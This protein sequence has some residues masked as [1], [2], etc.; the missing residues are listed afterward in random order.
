M[1]QL[2]ITLD[3]ELLHGLFTKDSRDEAFSKLLETILNQV[4]VAQSA[5][6]LGAERYERCEDRTAY[7]NGFRDRE[8][9]TRIGGITLRIPRHRNGEFSTTMFQRYQRSEQ[10]L[11]LAM[12]EMVI[13]GVS[14][15]KIE[16]ITEELC[17]Q[18]FSKSTVSKLCENLDPVVNGFRNRTL[19]KHYPFIIVDALY[20]KVRE[21]SR[22]RSKGLLVATAVNENGNREVIGFQLNDTETE[23][24]W[25]D[26]F[27]NLKE[28]GLTA[29]DLIVS[30]NH[31]GLVNAI[32]K[33]F[34]GSTWQRC[35]THFSRN[36]L[37]KT[38]KNQQSELKSYL[39]R[40]YNAVNIEDARNLLKDTLRHFESKAPKAIEIL[41]E[42]FDDVMA[43]MS[44]PEKYRKRLRTTNSIERLN[45]EIR[46]RD[47][48]IR[49][50]PNEKSV[51]RLLGALLMEQ[52]EKWSSGRK[53]LDMQDYYEF[54]KEQ[55]AAVSSAA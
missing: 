24:S 35:Q 38:P 14:T 5:E 25:G 27:Q 7:R 15:R 10:A 8:L 53:Y 11:M 46:R 43:V 6:Q 19:E 1:A 48:V 28:R 17:G 49:I 33:H 42:G 29:V 4:L 3:T 40:I 41:E 37:D 31:K 12:I 36:V 9:T 32:K 45:E 2:N 23:S 18:S 47:R 13:N 55:T 52:D 20:L 39:K 50:Y 21:D 22:V 54:L 51:I 30:D 16:N 26:F 34:Q 44:L